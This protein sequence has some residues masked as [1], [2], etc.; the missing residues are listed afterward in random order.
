MA[1]LAALREGYRMDARPGRGRRVEEAPYEEGGSVCCRM[2]GRR[3]AMRG[4][5]HF[6]RGLVQGPEADFV[7]GHEVAVVNVGIAV[8]EGAAEHRVAHAAGFVLD[9]EQRLVTVNIDDIQEAILVLIA[10]PR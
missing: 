1:R 9:S 8:D 10:F 4:S 3:A 5:M 2:A 6:V 7:A